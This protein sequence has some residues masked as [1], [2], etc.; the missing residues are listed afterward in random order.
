MRSSSCCS[1]NCT[2]LHPL[3]QPSHPQH[4]EHLA[5]LHTCRHASH[6]HHIYP[7]LHLLVAAATAALTPS[8][9]KYCTNNACWAW[10]AESIVVMHS[11]QQP[12]ALTHAY[13]A[14]VSAFNK[15]LCLQMCMCVLL[16]A[17]LTRQE[18]QCTLLVLIKQRAATSGTSRCTV[19]ILRQIAKSAAVQHLRLL[20]PIKVGTS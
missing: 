6:K 10:T 15:L 4:A 12:S 5:C 7:S 2:Q 17:L 8:Q 20:P 9:R 19:C 14:A 1:V 3:Q 16:R 13:Q 11:A 18:H